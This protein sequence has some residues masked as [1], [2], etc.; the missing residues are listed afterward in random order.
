M[1]TADDKNNVTVEWTEA[2]RVA[3]MVA[4][5]VDPTPLTCSLGYVLAASFGTGAQLMLPA[6]FTAAADMLPF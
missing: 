2:I 6:L 1:F 5:K 3:G 4:N